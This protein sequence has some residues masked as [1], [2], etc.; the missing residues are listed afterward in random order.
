MLPYSRLDRSTLIAP[1]VVL[2]TIL[3]NFSILNIGGY[4]V[5]IAPLSALALLALAL[6]P[7]PKTLFT[8]LFIASSVL[9]Y[10]LVAA[11]F[12]FFGSTVHLGQFMSSFALLV[13][14]LLVISYSMGSRARHFSSPALT[15]ALTVTGVLQLICISWQKIVFSTT[16]ST[17][18]FNVWGGRLAHN[19]EYVIR[20]IEFGSQRATSFYFEPSFAALVVFFIASGLNALHALTPWRLVMLFI[21]SALIGSLAGLLA[22]S[23]LCFTPYLRGASD[24]S[25]WIPIFSAFCALAALILFQ[26]YIMSRLMSASDSSSSLSYRLISPWV[27]IGDVLINHPL[28]M[29]MGHLEENIKRFDMRNGDRVGSSLDN[30]WYLIIYHFGWLGL[31]FNVLG[32]STFAWKLFSKRNQAIYLFALLSPFFTGAIFSPELAF[33]YVILIIIHRRMEI[34]S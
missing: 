11:I 28:G 19:Q 34:R 9:I 10:A 12:T 5:T 24:R 18:V 4:S 30:G 7:E 1:I 8:L 16:A 3:L 13:F 20:A 17:E 27:V 23:A 21:C 14:S 6:R 25:S 15:Q 29:P 26:D 2:S 31:V 32:I 33:M 22:L